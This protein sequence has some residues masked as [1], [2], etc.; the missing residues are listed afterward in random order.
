MSEEVLIS[1]PDPS[2]EVTDVTV[3]QE[4][5]NNIASV[6]RKRNEAYW[7]SIAAQKELDA[8]N[9]TCSELLLAI[10]DQNHC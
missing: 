1:T 8:L 7:A 6:M 5:R 2:P 9:P 3:E 4:R 10:E